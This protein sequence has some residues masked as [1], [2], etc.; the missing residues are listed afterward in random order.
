MPP[1]ARDRHIE[2]LE[3]RRLSLQGKRLSKAQRAR[4]AEYEAEIVGTSDSSAP[5]DPEFDALFS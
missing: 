1:E 3:L 2:F 4:L 5:K